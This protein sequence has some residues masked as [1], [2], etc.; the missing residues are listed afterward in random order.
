MDQRTRDDELG[1]AERTRAVVVRPLWARVAMWVAVVL[2]ILLLVAIVVVW[3]E[4]RPIATHFLKGEFESRGVQAKYHL[5][6]VGFRTQQVSDLVIGDPAHPDLIAKK[7]IIQMRLKLDG[8]FRV[9]RVVARGVRLRG[10]LVHGRVNWGQIDKLLPPP[11]NKPFQLPNIVLDV[12]DSSISLATPFGPVGIALEGN[13][14]LS[15]GFKGRTAVASP[16][17]TLGRCTA[18]GFTRTLHSLWSRAIPKWKGRSPWGPSFAPRAASTSR[19]QVRRQGELQR[20]VDSVDGTGRMAISTLTAGANGLAALIGYISYKGSLAEV[21]GAGASFGA[22]VTHGD[23]D[24]REDAPECRL[25]AGHA[26]RHVRP[27]R[28]FRLR[29]FDARSGNA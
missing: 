18:I 8:S 14:R 23:G 20:V 12:A 17:L 29:Q 4:R 13:G 19:A 9:Y 28:Q 27:R 15:G 2:L 26:Q 1:A 16:Q 22:K 21:A 6:R 24:C 5:D 11:S 3:I 10:R 7:A 25:S